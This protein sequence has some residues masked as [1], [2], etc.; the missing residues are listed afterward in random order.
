MY[1]VTSGSMSRSSA[2]ASIWHRPKAGG[3]RRSAAL[4]EAF[5]RRH[6]T[7][8]ARDWQR[9]S[10]RTSSRCTGSCPRGRSFRIT[11]PDRRLWGTGWRCC[12]VMK[13]RCRQRPGRQRNRR[14]RQNKA[15][16]AK[17]RDTTHACGA[18]HQPSGTR[19]QGSANAKLGRSAHAQGGTNSEHKGNSYVT[20]CASLGASIISSAS[21]AEAYW[22]S[23]CATG[24]RGSPMWSRPCARSTPPAGRSAAAWALRSWPPSWTRSGCAPR[25][26][27]EP[28]WCCA[29]RSSRARGGC[30]TD[31][32]RRCRGRG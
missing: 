20:G 21:S 17:S 9:R 25:P 32:R 26:G 3:R 22:R 27:R 11:P 8:P 14:L 31:R 16:A 2:S 12:R 30:R 13:N 24:E 29:A 23:W 6:R 1:G 5:L 19:V 18:V 15:S 7:V 4:P 10:C 28:R